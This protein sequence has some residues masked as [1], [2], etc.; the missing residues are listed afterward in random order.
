MAAA[1]AE[2]RRIEQDLHDGAQASLVALALKARM[3]RDLAESEPGKTA[4]ILA[5]LGEDL[6]R[7]IEEVRDLAQGIY[8]PLLAERGLKA[9]LSSAAA[10]APLPVRLEVDGS[11]RYPADVEAAVYFCCLEAVQNAEKHAG[12]DA[13]VTIRLQE[14]AGALAFEVSDDGAGFNPRALGRGSGLNNMADRLG[15]IGGR[16]RVES[17]PGAGTR[18]AGTLP[19]EPAE[20]KPAPEAER[21]LATV[22]FTDIVGSTE[23]AASLGDR[24]WNELLE[25]HHAAVRR[26]LEGFGGREVKTTG[27]GFLAT[28]GGP[29][30]AIRC[31]CAVTRTVQELGLDIR[32]G[33]HTG[34]CE[35]SGDDVGGIAV[36]I[37]ARV[38]G[39]ADGGEV[40]VSS[41]VRDLVAGSGIEFED[42]G[43][44]ELKGVPGEWRLYKVVDSSAR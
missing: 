22:L 25:A 43:V 42:R 16:L 11:R 8:P 9:A 44:T 3:A 17:A 33:L 34:E 27:D 40:L 41:T 29:A 5:E 2:R 39:K 4:E 14:Q 1:D 36:H 15:A 30:Q 21:V 7:T 32:A 38:A 18:V 26:E 19:I 24:R 20:S 6:E 13:R 31:A 28:F 23:R 35:V 10:R 37:G 12:A